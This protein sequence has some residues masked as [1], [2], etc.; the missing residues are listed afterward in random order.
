VTIGSTDTVHECCSCRDGRASKGVKLRG[1]FLTL[2][3]SGGQP[4]EW[5]AKH[6]VGVTGAD[7]KDVGGTKRA[8]TLSFQLNGI[9]VQRLTL[10][11]V[12]VNAPIPANT[13]AVSDEVKAKAKAAA[14]DAPYQW[15]LRRLFL[16]RFL[17][18]DK[19]YYP[20]AAA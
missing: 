10:K 20:E 4:R 3:G 15:V 12:T 14:T 19:V 18:S 9:E 2:K 13:F 5:P 7:W 6:V 8:H 1:S 17:D 16:G 11:E